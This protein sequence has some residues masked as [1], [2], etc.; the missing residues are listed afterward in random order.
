MTV[1]VKLL[2]CTTLAYSYTKLASIMQF[3][4]KVMPIQLPYKVIELFK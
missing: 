2:S 4:S 3:N 1:K